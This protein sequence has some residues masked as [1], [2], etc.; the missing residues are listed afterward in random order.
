MTLKKSPQEINAAIATFCNFQ[1]CPNCDDVGYYC[2]NSTVDVPDIE[3]CEWCET[4]AN[5]I[6]HAPNFFESLH[7]LHT[8][9]SFLTPKQQL[10]YITHICQGLNVMEKYVCIL[11]IFPILFQVANANI[12][13]RLDALL[14]VIKPE[15]FFD[16]KI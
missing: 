9:E 3:Q 1:K 13:I 14:R 5:S 6:F 10:E 7:H 12:D 8:A 15:W 4:T 16:V 2:T 11:N